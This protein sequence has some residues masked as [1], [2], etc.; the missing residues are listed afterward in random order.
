MEKVKILEG[1]VV[2]GYGK[3]A[4]IEPVYW[5]RDRRQTELCWGLGRW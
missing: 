5:P 1:K 4:E 3:N 2:G